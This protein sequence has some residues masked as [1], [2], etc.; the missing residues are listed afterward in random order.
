[1]LSSIDSRIIAEIPQIIARTIDVSGLYDGTIVPKKNPNNISN[2]N[3]NTRI[4]SQYLSVH[5]LLYLD[6]GNRS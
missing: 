6:S 5:P 4:T 2:H 1:M 3:I